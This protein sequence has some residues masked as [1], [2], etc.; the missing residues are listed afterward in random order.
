MSHDHDPHEEG[1]GIS[2]YAAYAGVVLHSS[3]ALPLDAPQSIIPPHFL[4][5]NPHYPTNPLN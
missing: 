1:K 2:T 5:H 3:T 4:Y